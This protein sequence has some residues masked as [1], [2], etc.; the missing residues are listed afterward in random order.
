[1]AFTMQADSFTP[2]KCEEREASAVHEATIP[3]ASL[4]P[5]QPCELPCT[6]NQL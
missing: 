2:P 5:N 4:I 1:L 6:S 3:V